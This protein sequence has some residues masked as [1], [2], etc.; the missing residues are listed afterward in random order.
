MT[1]VFRQKK[2][3]ASNLHLFF[4]PAMGADLQQMDFSR[5][6]CAG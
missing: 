6:P 2:F 4:M 3:R 5:W 1:G